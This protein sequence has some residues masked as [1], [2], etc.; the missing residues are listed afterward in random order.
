[1]PTKAENIANQVQLDV[2]FWTDNG[3]SLEQRFT[4]WA[5]K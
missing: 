4:A 1:M 3:E 5:A 2:A